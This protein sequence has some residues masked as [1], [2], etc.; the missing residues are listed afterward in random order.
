MTVAYALVVALG[1]LGA[2]RF[3]LGRVR[4]ATTQMMLSFAA[5]AAVVVLVG[6]PSALVLAAVPIAAAGW[7]LIDV[8]RTA[9]M[10]REHNRRKPTRSDAPGYERGWPT[11]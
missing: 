4:S 5:A 7:W 11:A 1:L 8:F 10:V 2:H 9:G 3:Y 6:D